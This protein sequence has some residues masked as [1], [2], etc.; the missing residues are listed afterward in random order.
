M[1]GVSCVPVESMLFKYMLIEVPASER[2]HCDSQPNKKYSGRLGM[3]H[4]KNMEDGCT[5]LSPST[6]HQK[7]E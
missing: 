1:G 7:P 3:G 2:R 5:Y 4:E 6:S